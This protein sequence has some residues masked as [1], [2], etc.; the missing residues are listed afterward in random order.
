MSKTL[1]LLQA[2][3][4]MM[5]RRRNIVILI[6]VT[7]MACCASTLLLANSKFVRG[8]FVS[9]VYDNKEH[10]LSCEE[11]P[12][13]TE[14]IKTLD[15]HEDIIYKI[16][17]AHPGFITVEIDTTSCPGK[18]DIIIWYPTHQDRFAIEKLIGDDT[19]FGIP[20]RLRNY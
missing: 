17:Q 4:T 15:E 14:V 11:L 7:L 6:I 3:Q 16:E 9:Y 18:A 10:F 5:N 19:F 20:Y 1:Y 13:Q 2:D 8:L 12:L